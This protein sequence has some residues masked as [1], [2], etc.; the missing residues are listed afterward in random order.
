MKNYNDQLTS[1][2]VKLYAAALY[3]LYQCRIAQGID[4]INELQRY[5]TGLGLSRKIVVLTV[6]AYISL[7]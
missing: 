1:Q 5:M 3:D 7:L 4:T 6:L 2:I